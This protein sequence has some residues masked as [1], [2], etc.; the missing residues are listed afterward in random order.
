[1]RGK[2]RIIEVQCFQ[3]VPDLGKWEKSNMLIH[4]VNCHHVILRFA[5]SWK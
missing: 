3:L 4:I 2:Y 5:L 1:M